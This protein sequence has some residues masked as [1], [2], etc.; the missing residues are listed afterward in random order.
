MSDVNCPECPGCPLCDHPDNNKPL[1]F[2]GCC[3]K[4]DTTFDKIKKTWSN[5]ENVTALLSFLALDC[6]GVIWNYRCGDDEGERGTGK[7]RTVVTMD[8]CQ[9]KGLLA[10]DSLMKALNLKDNG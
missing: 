9:L 10:D 7:C 6:H 2:L 8:I 5:G 4:W 3:F 1:V